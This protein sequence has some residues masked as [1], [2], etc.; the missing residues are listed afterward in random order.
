MRR[1]IPIAGGRAAGPHLHGVVLPGGGDWQII[2]PDGSVDI[3]VRCTVRAE[4]G[5]HLLVH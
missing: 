4:D 3:D 5:S 2:R 1:V